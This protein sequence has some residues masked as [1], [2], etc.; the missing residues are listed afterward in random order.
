MTKTRLSR[1]ELKSE[2]LKSLHNPD[3][4]AALRDL[5]NL[6]LASTINA[7]LGTLLHPEPEIRW[8]GITAC[9]ILIGDLAKIDL[10]SA[11]SNIRRQLWNLTE[12]SGGCATGAPELIGEALTNDENLALEFSPSF[13][14][15]IMPEGI[16]LD[17][18]P[19]QSGVVWGIGRLA[20]KYPELLKSAVH[21]LIPLL[22][23]EEATI[24]GLSA[25]AIGLIQPDFNNSKIK[26]ITEDESR[27]KV[28]LNMK[29]TEISIRN[30]CGK[31]FQNLHI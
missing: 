6:P 9:G 12:E 2:I 13:I 16:Y 1:R 8:F 5:R 4:F 29:L 18:V 15:H 10:E 25:Y 7:L 21:Y 22:E 14:T 27:I 28:F 20:G 30:L 31:S 24:R 19:L 3:F 11:R 23:S 26:T 17:F